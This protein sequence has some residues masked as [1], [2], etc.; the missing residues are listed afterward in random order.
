MGLREAILNAKKIQEKQSEN[1]IDR[2][3]L[4]IFCCSEKQLKM[5]E[6]LGIKEGYCYDLGIYVIK[7]EKLL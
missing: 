6:F 4:S 3:G 1:Y 2:N 7:T 5:W